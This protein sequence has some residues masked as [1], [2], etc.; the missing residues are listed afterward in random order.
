[1]YQVLHCFSE[2]KLHFKENKDFGLVELKLEQR[3]N[4]EK[5]WSGQ[6]SSTDSYVGELQIFGKTAANIQGSENEVKIKY[7]SLNRKRNVVNKNQRQHYLKNLKDLSH[8]KPTSFKRKNLI[9]KTDD[10]NSLDSYQKIN[11]Q[12]ELKYD[13]DQSD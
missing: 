4:N 3:R 1:M 8:I 7:P 6:S 13:L 10:S 11:E 2:D 9:I 12:T 5:L